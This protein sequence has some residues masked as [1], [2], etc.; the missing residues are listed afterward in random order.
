[1]PSITMPGVQWCGALAGCGRDMAR[2]GSKEAP[3]GGRGSL[4]D[5]RRKIRPGARERE[6]WRGAG[7]LPFVTLAALPPRRFAHR[8]SPRY[9]ALASA[10]AL[11]ATA[12]CQSTK[13]AAS[14]DPA[15]SKPPVAVVPT[16]TATA[17]TTQP[18]NS[19]FPEDDQPLDMTTGYACGGDCPSPFELASEDKDRKQIQAR[20]EFCVARA[21]QLE[22]VPK[23]DFVVRGEIDGRGSAHKVTL[24]P[25]ADTLQPALRECLRELVSSARFTPPR[26]G[27]RQRSLWASVRTHVK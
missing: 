11:I 27:G 1:L 3:P 6:L 18:T 25:P 2:Q 21:E 19:R 22:P 23:V 17:T 16:A 15:A 8:P 20:V 9:P 14:P 13:P 26:R 10:C 7:I 5:V 24:E 4:R 12:A